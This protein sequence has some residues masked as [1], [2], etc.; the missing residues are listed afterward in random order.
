MSYVIRDVKNECWLVIDRFVNMAG[1]IITGV[2]P[3]VSCFPA[4]KF[5]SV[6]DAEEA[7]A[8]IKAETDYSL[9]EYVIETEEEVKKRMKEKEELR[10]KKIIVYGEQKMR[11]KIKEMLAAGKSDEEIE[12]RVKQGIELTPKEMEEAQKIDFDE[13][14]LSKTKE[15]KDF[16]EEVKNSK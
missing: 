6:E 15:V 4:S 16:I 13:S 1:D 3:V 11:E 9:D 10:Q 7:I 5:T 12:V 14:M 8:M 2:D